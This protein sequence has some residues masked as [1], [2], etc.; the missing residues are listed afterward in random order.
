[1]NLGNFV[2]LY[3]RVYCLTAYG[4]SLYKFLKLLLLTL[5]FDQL[6]N[7]ALSCAENDEAV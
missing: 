3:P 7:T 4:H 6:F 5:C 1:M 2:K